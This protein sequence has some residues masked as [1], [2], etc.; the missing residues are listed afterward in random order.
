M[1]VLS[2]SGNLATAKILHNRIYILQDLQDDSAQEMKLVLFDDTAFLD[3]EK[4]YFVYYDRALRSI[5]YSFGKGE[6][7]RAGE[8]HFSNDFLLVSGTIQDGTGQLR[9]VTGST[10]QVTYVTQVKKNGNIIE[11]HLLT[12]GAKTNTSTGM[13]ETFY[14]LDDTDISDTTACIKVDP[15]TWETTIIKNDGFCGISPLDSVS[16]EIV[17]DYR[18]EKFTGTYK[19]RDIGQEPKIYDFVG[20]ATAESLRQARA[21]DR[22]W[23]AVDG[24]ALE[25][26][27]HPNN[28]TQELRQNCVL[29]S[30]PNLLEL[31]NISPVD[32]I[33]RAGEQ[34]TID[35][36]QQKSMEY[37]QNILISCLEQDT[38]RDFFGSAPVLTD[39]VSRIKETYKDF[40][41]KHALD[42]MAQILYDNCRTT[43]SDAQKKACERIKQDVVKT[44]W[45]KAAQEDPDYQAQANALY[46]E[47]YRDSVPSIASY[48]E[49]G[50]EWAKK[51]FDY[52]TSPTFL[53]LWRIQIASL[54]YDNVK[55]RMYGFYSKLL[56][57]DS[58]KEGE[59]RAH[60]ALNT[61]FS[62][63]LTTGGHLAVY[64]DEARDDI[65]RILIAEIESITKNPEKLPDSIKEYAKLY[66]EAAKTFISTHFFVGTLIKEIAKQYKKLPVGAEV[67]MSRLVVI[68]GDEL[69]HENT[70]FRNIWEDASKANLKNSLLFLVSAAAAGYMIYSMVKTANKETLKPEDIVEELSMGELVLLSLVKGSEYLMETQLG[71]WVTKLLSESE[72]TFLKFAEGVSKWFTK[73]GIA[74]DHIFARLFGKNSQVFC[75]RIL[76][77]AVLLT[78]IVLGGYL[79]A[80]AIKIGDTKEIVLEAL[81]LV[82]L[83]GE[84]VS[85]GLA[86]SG[87]SWAGPLGT[88]FMVVGII[89][90][91]IQIIWEIFDPPKGPVEAYVDKKL[92]PAGLAEA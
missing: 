5:H 33:V 56:V 38:I 66:Q 13:L 55:D 9:Q 6:A 27:P 1:S 2:R 57:L 81:N 54:V 67:P 41:Q 32:V 60:K 71:K 51:L 12:I 72:N 75:Q 30:E 59:A 24:E 83:V 7:Y 21:M 20:Q 82:C 11:D 4:L 17:I 44:N 40:Y 76:A 14:T 64:T 69:A 84:L 90:M 53:N 73:E 92:V 50:V 46:L 15:V 48:L 28:L 77:P 8:L 87:F 26:C 23:K 52:L 37:F 25:H 10:T 91:A 19:V 61:M 85:W 35:R 31:I 63:V 3:G 42:N 78:A 65:E 47:G 49:K 62:V 89:I 88:V 58:S 79:L 45:S 18:G 74:A 39:N 86:M 22:E 43:G 80:D 16:F 36:A 29:A 34:Y 68:A 70:E